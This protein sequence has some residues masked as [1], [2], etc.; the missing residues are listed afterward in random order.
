MSSEE[1][2]LNKLLD[3]FEPNMKI[4]PVSIIPIVIRTIE[5]VDKYVKGSGEDKKKVC[6]SVLE[7][8]L[9][10][11]QIND[12][13]MVMSFLATQLF[14]FIDQVI[15]ISRGEYNI[16]SFFQKIK[17]SFSKLQCK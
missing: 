17:R 14:I 4:D 15:K 11:Y 16:N 8:L 12:K 7:K 9:Q 10:H 6:Y 2:V 3:S 13:D 5:V 1:K